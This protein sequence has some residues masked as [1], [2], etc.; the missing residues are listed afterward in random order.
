V[1]A[2]AQEL[3][4]ALLAQLREG[5]RM[6]VPVGLPDTQQL[7]LIRVQDRRPVTTLREACRFVPLVAGV[8]E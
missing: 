6:I 4:Q 8:N 1:A 7:Q 2:A 3:P 5:G